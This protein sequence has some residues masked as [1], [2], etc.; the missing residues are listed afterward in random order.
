MY[1][2]STDDQW[3]ITINGQTGEF[4]EIWNC[5]KYE[6]EWAQYTLSKEEA[7][8]VAKELYQKLG[9]RQ[10]EYQLIKMIPQ[11]ED[12]DMQKEG[13]EFDARFYKQYDDLYN[14]YQCVSISFYVKDKILKCY[15][16]ENEKF[17]NNPVELTKEEAIEIA[18]KE[19]RKV[20]NKEIIS[21][22]AELRIEKMNG[23][24]YARV[25]NTEEYYKP[26]TTTDVPLEEQVHYQTENRVRRVW[27]VS[28]NYGEE[29]GTDV[30]TRYAKGTYSYFVDATTGEIIGGTTSDYLR[31]NNFW[32]K[33]YAV[34]SEE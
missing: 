13:Y 8:Q 5:Q 23:N 1:R 25:Y 27:V 11:T 22:E 19:D 29:P 9:Y 21:I 26:M 18:T 14:G 15:R 2:F 12:G 6:K 16:V 30:V 17:D 34:E 28:F 20:E 33:Q 32:E 4:F 7:I 31:W 24:A 10:G 3:S